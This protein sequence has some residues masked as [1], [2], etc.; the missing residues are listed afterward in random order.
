VVLKYRREDERMGREVI[1]MIDRFLT[2]MRG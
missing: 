1:D 2:G